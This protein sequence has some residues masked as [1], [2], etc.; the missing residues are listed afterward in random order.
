MMHNNWSANL[1]NFWGKEN[2]KYAISYINGF[3]FVFRNVHAYDI[4]NCF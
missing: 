3:I 2:V 1:I 4:N